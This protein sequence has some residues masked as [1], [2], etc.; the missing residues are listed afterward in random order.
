MLRHKILVPMAALGLL[1]SVVLVPTAHAKTILG[2]FSA[3]VFV[4]VSGALNESTTVTG[5]RSECEMSHFPAVKGAFG[6]PAHTLLSVS[7]NAPGIIANPPSAN[8]FSIEMTYEPRVTTYSKGVLLSIVLNKHSYLHA[9]YSGSV[10]AHT[11]NKGISGTFS[12][13]GMA[14]NNGTKGHTINISGHWACSGFINM[15]V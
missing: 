13:T 7:V 2:A 6:S 11:M 4:H 12:A 9:H 8:A 5:A 10:T 14:P 1:T 15:T 3:V